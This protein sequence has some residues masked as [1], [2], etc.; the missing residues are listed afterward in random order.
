M[1][2]MI[3][4]R[5]SIYAHLIKKRVDLPTV[6]THFTTTTAHLILHKADAGTDFKD[7]EHCGRQHKNRHMKYFISTRFQKKGGNIIF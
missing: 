3:P 2:A 1:D 5:M 6:K 4:E 7:H